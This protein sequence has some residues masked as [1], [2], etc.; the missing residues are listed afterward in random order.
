MQNKSRDEGRIASYQLSKSTE[1]L[2]VNKQGMLYVFEHTVQ[3]IIDFHDKVTFI[4]EM[5][6]TMCPDAIGSTY[7]NVVLQCF[8]FEIKNS[9]L[10]TTQII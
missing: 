1:Q 5:I 2:R 8:I 10:S 9:S 4:C 6:K 3:P 7:S